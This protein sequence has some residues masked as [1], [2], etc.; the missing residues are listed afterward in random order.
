MSAI[1]PI[2]HPHAYHPAFLAV[3]EAWLLRVGSAWAGT[4]AQIPIKHGGRQTTA[5][6][7]RSTALGVYQ[8]NNSNRRALGGRIRLACYLVLA[9]VGG[10]AELGARAV[11]RVGDARFLLGQIKKGVR[12][13][14]FGGDGATWGNYG[15]VWQDA[16]TAVLDYGNTHYTNGN[17]FNFQA[18]GATSP[19]LWHDLAI[20]AI[21]MQQGTNDV[22]FLAKAQGLGAT[23]VP[24][25]GKGNDEAVF[26]KM[27]MPIAYGFSAGVLLSHE[28]SQFDATTSAGQSVKYETD[29]RPSG[30]FGVA[31]QSD[32]KKWLFGF[33]AL[34]NNDFERRM[35]STSI[36]EGI[37]ESQEYRLGGSYQVWKGG[38]IDIGATRIE[39]WNAI[40]GTHTVTYDPNLGFEQK[41]FDNFTFRFSINETSPTA[42]FTYRFSPF[43]LDVSYVHD[44]AKAPVSSN[45][46]GT[47]SDS[48]LATLTFDFAPPK[49]ASTRGIGELPAAKVLR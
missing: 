9:F 48:V 28:T 35:N 24:M 29:W 45:L 31:W 2:S 41:V 23:A 46:F 7:R 25:V 40:A 20:Y 32:D 4:Y 47:T 39:K 38:L 5:R 1:N 3:G 42:G 16:N 8:M 22:K 33:R 13:I 19:S 26:V 10:F 11:T 27:A 43:K 6:K 15:L 17:D 14:G 36:T 12:S 49:S 34:Y 37:A 18:V 21:A 44:M 30:G